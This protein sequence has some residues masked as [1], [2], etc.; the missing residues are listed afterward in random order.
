[1]AAVHCPTC[2]KPY[3]DR[4][5]WD[6]CPRC[7]G[8]SID[9]ERIYL[10]R[11]RAE[12]VRAASAVALEVR[13]QEAELWAV[14]AELREREEKLR[15]AAAILAR[16]VPDVPLVNTLAPGQGP[17]LVIPTPDPDG[18]PAPDRFAAPEEVECPRCAEKIKARAKVCRFCGHEFEA[19]EEEEEE[20]DEREERALPRRRTP[21]SGRHRTESRDVYHHYHP[22]GPNPF[23]AVGLSMVFTGLGHAYCGAAGRGAA[24]FVVGLCAVFATLAIGGGSLDSRTVAWLLG[25]LV[26][27]LC[28]VDAFVVAG[29]RSKPP[30]RTRRY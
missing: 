17:D 27:L 14:E 4:T 11:Q 3:A 24:W 1:M 12:E 7:G 9:G 23:V 29:D 30:P 26:H 22:P 13:R 28:V 2:D 19:V 10:A 18:E 8:R 6:A 20:D 5:G 25:G 15:E 16:P 21:S